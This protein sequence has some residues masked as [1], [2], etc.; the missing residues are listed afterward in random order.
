LYWNILPDGRFCIGIPL[1]AEDFVL[2]YPS[3]LTEDFEL[4]YPY[5]LK[6]SYWN[7]LPH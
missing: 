3:L 2:E 6:I 5:W 7:T 4:E 1:L